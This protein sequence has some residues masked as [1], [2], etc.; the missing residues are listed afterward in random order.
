[1]LIRYFFYEKTSNENFNKLSSL[2]LKQ[3]DNQKSYTWAAYSLQF[4]KPPLFLLYSYMCRHMERVC[5]CWTKSATGGGR[6]RDV[7]GSGLGL[8]GELLAVLKQVSVFIAEA[9]TVTGRK[10]ALLLPYLILIWEPCSKRQIKKGE[11]I[12][13]Q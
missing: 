4:H 6:A 11:F 8:K 5:T 9:K 10:L 1:M 7:S 12:P 13:W 3:H 2:I